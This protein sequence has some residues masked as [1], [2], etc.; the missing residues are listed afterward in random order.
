MSVFFPFYLGQRRILGRPKGPGPGAPHHV[1]VLSH[2]CVMCV[3]L[4]HIYRGKNYCRKL[5]DIVTKQL[6]HLLVSRKSF[7]YL[8]LVNARPIHV[9]R[10]SLRLYYSCLVNFAQHRSHVS[11][12]V[13]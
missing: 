11:S 7:K 12:I 8:N 4:R 9:E 2:M 3:P 6:L 13:M 5:L 1:H 10:I